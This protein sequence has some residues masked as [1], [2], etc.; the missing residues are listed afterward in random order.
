MDDFSQVTGLVNKHHEMVQEGYYI[1]NSK[2]EML[3][4]V[5]FEISFPNK[6]KFKMAN[7]LKS[8]AAGIGAGVIM[9]GT[10][11]GLNYLNNKDEESY[12]RM[13]DAQN[14]SVVS[15]LKALETP[16]LEDDS[17]VLESLLWRA[18]GQGLADN[19]NLMNRLIYLRNVID[20]LN[21]EN[22]EV[23]KSYKEEFTSIVKELAE[24][25]IYYDLNSYEDSISG[26]R[27][28]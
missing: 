3:G 26:G 15:S 24:M 21:V 22:S 25:G 17:K 11:V 1:K 16:S 5:K 6:R 8:L 7:R 27:K 9:V 19:Q 13:K 28:Q 2:N 18:N 23:I 14:E 12:N 20:N 4:K 10:M